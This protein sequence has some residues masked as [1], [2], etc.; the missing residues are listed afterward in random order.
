MYKC[1]SCQQKARL[2]EC[3]HCHRY[4]CEDCGDRDAPC[5]QDCLDMEA[6]AEAE[7]I[8]RAMRRRKEMMENGQGNA[9]H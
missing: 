2:H 9:A 6:W 1:P 7:K 4:F 5:C 8:D 3:E